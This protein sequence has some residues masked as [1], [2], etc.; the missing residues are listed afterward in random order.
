[1][2]LQRIARIINLVGLIVATAR[3]ALFCEFIELA[4]ESFDN[5]AKDKLSNFLLKFR[6]Q[7]KTSMIVASG[8]TAREHLGNLLVEAWK[9][10]YDELPTVSQKIINSFRMQLKG[11]QPESTK[12]RSVYLQAPLRPKLNQEN[13]RG[14]SNTNILDRMAA[15][16]QSVA[17]ENTNQAKLQPQPVAGGPQRKRK[18]RGEC[19]KC[20]SH[21]V[22]LAK[23][24]SGDEYFSC[25]YCGFQAYR[26]AIDMKIDLPLAAE[27]LSRRF[28][29]RDKG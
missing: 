10:D 17:E 2:L 23:S 7:A 9:N 15:I 19:P 22:V 27:L 29:E 12:D 4:R 21:G 25:I 5:K 24:Y 11:V 14:R 8:I 6:I 3:E 20:H 16:G 13:L 26:N 28:D 18:A 1:M